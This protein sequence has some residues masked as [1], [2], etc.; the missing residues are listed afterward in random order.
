MNRRDFL[1][2]PDGS[3]SGAVGGQSA[4]GQGNMA[5]TRP[6]VTH[7]KQALKRASKE[8]HWNGVTPV[9]EAASGRVFLEALQSL[10]QEGEL[11][12]EYATHILYRTEWLTRELRENGDE[13]VSMARE[14]GSKHVDTRFV[15]VIMDGNPVV[16][17]PNVANLDENGDIEM[18]NILEK[19]IGPNLQKWDAAGLTCKIYAVG[20]GAIRKTLDD[21]AALRESN[22]NGP[23]HEIAHC[24]SVGHGKS[25]RFSSHSWKRTNDRPAD[26]PRFRELSITAEMSP[27]MH[28]KTKFPPPNLGF[29][30]PGMLAAQNLVTVGSDWAVGMSLPLFPSVAHL[31]EEVGADRVIEMLTIN[32]AKSVA[33]DMVGIVL[34]SPRCF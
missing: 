27:A 6:T 14:Y 3:L 19:N 23:R 25:S 1:R 32:G 31:V 33:K 2:R 9:Q 24:V 12:M 4:M 16:P 21:F 29:N 22:P 10:D 18:A 5:V 26:I 34:T 30:F 28:F 11:K 13:I 7:V 15:K 8:L 17:S 20:S